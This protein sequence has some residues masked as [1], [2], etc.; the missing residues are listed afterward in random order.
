MSQYDPKKVVLTFLGNIITGYAEDTFIDFDREED[1]W[2]MHVGA[3]GE[4][5]WTKNANTSGKLTL[6]LMQTSISNDVLSTLQNA[7]ELTG[8]AVGPLA[9]KDLSGTSVIL[10]ENARLMRPAKTTYAKQAGPREYVFACLDSKV[11]NGGNP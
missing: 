4:G 7:D 1:S 11:F 10:C 3:D 2:F 6:T 9:M 8:S 5:A